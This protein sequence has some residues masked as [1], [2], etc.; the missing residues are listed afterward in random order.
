LP[1]G[2]KKKTMKVLIRGSGGR[3]HALAH[4]ISQ[5][6]ACERVFMAPGNGGT[7]GVAEPVQ[8]DPMNFD[9]LAGYVHVN[10]I[11]FVVVGPEAPLVAGLVDYL[12]ADARTCEVPVF[13]PNKMAAQLEGSKDFAKGFMLR[14]GIPTACYATF[15]GSEYAQAAEYVA[16]KGAPIV[17]KADGLAAGKG[18]R[19]CLAPGE[20]EDALRDMLLDGKYGAAGAKVVVEDYL[21]GRELSVFAVCDGKEYVLLPTAKDYKRVG[22]GDSGPNTGGMGAVSPVWY[23]DADFMEKVDSQVVRPTMRGLRADG[24]DYRGF[25]YFGLMRVAGEPY[26]IEYNCRMGDPETEAVLPRIKSDLLPL[27]YAAARGGLGPQAAVDLYPQACATVVLASAGYP[28]EYSKGK[29]IK[30]GGA[31]AGAMIYHAGTALENHVLTTAGGRVMAVSALGD[32]LRDAL[33]I[34]YAQIEAVRYEGK[35]YRR[36]IGLDLGG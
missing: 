15:A 13:G 34:C 7:V 17:L 35:V 23:A 8:I 19:V 9:Q 33:G 1:A 16:R 5:S 18:V 24:I 12:G 29:A 11:D 26:V 10:K 30:I 3:E 32:R 22:E 20:A 2:T 27:L 28:G 14:H 4:K 21:D 31:V 36:D 25:L 6:K